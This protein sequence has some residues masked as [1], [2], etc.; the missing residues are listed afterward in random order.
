VF[1]G[2][3]ADIA[4]LLAGGTVILAAVIINERYL[5]GG[6]SLAAGAGRAGKR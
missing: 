3:T 2:E 5:R 1:F 6:E 4:R